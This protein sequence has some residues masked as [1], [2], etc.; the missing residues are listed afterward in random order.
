[1]T[2]PPGRTP[3][4]MNDLSLKMSLDSIKK[5]NNELKTSTSK[6]PKIKTCQGIM[7]SEYESTIREISKLLVEYK[8]LLAKDLEDADTTREFFLQVDRDIKAA[9]NRIK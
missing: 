6:V 2:V 3:I 8:K 9:F 7:V 5:K 4:S 1:M